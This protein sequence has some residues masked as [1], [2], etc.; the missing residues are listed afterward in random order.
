MQSYSVPLILA[1]RSRLN[2]SSR[3]DGNGAPVKYG[4]EI[5]ASG[6]INVLAAAA[7]AAKLANVIWGT[8]AKNYGYNEIYRFLGM[9]LADLELGQGRI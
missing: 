6:N 3:N 4:L 8:D 7:A 5:N 1:L 9:R 2:K